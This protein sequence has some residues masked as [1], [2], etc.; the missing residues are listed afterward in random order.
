MQEHNDLAQV[1]SNETGT[2]PLQPMGFTDILTGCSVS[3][4]ATS[5]CF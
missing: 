3:I 2:T 1:N 4:G 5:G